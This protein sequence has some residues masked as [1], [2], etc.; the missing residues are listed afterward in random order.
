MLEQIVQVL[1]KYAD[2]N[3]ILMGDFNVIRDENLDRQRKN[4]RETANKNF[5]KELDEQTQVF[6][7]VDI[8]RQRN[9]NKKE[10]TW[11]RGETASRLD[12]ILIKEPMCNRVLEVYMESVAASDHRMVIMEYDLRVPRRGPGFWKFNNSI[13][14]NNDYI[15]MMTE[16]LESKKWEVIE[17]EPKTKWEY[18]KFQ[19]KLR[20]IEFTKNLARERRRQ[21][22]QDQKRLEYLESKDDWDEGDIEEM[23]C[24][25]REIRAIEDNRASGALIRSRVRWLAEGENQPNIS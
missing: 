3:T 6:D 4:E 12:L 13:L 21:E 8:W 24:L 14:E 18:L 9:P 23:Q 15:M 19:V 11:R 22:E 16:F 2:V 10:F 5:K 20:T 17:E 25:K 7:L 1:G